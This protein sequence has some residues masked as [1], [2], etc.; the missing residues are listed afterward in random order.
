MSF[1]TPR[2][3]APEGWKASHPEA[4]PHGDDPGFEQIFDGQMGNINTRKWALARHLAK[5]YGVN[6]VACPKWV[7]K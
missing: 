2:E 1:L 5:I 6:P 3:H 4:A 7:A